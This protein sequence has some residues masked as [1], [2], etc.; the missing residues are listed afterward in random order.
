MSIAYASVG[1]HLLSAAGKFISLNEAHH[2]PCIIFLKPKCAVSLVK[3]KTFLC[4]A[5]ALQKNVTAFASRK[6]FTTNAP[7]GGA[8]LQRWQKKYWRWIVRW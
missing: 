5:L 8:A 4:S 6:L 3:L 1:L 2:V 7:R